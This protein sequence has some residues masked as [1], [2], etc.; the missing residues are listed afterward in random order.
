VVILCELDL[1]EPRFDQLL[2]TALTR[3]TVQ[4]VLVV[5]PELAQ[6]LR[7]VRAAVPVTARGGVA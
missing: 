2:Y 6:R 5:T 7:S 1:D 4:V 3:A